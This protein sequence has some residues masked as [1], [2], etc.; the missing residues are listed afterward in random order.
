M[1]A[2]SKKTLLNLAGSAAGLA[3]SFIPG[4]GPVA[5]KILS[6]FLSNAG[7]M[8]ISGE[9]AVKTPEEIRDA[10]NIHGNYKDGGYAP[11]SIKATHGGFLKPLTEDVYIAS[12]RTHAAGGIG[13]DTNADGSPELE[14][15]DNE[16]YFDFDD[17]GGFFVNA[18]TSEKYKNSF[19]NR[20]DRISAETNNVVKKLA[21]AENEK[22]RT[23][24]MAEKLFASKGSVKMEAGGEW[25]PKTEFLAPASTYSFADPYAPNAAVSPTTFTPEFKYMGNASDYSFAK[26]NGTTQTTPT[27]TPTTDEPVYTTTAPGEQPT[28]AK[29]SGEMTSG[30]KAILA[31]QM[32]PVVYNLARG[33]FEKAEE[34]KP[35]YHPYEDTV[36]GLMKDRVYNPQ[37]V[38][39]QI[40]YAVEAGKE[41]ITE[42]TTSASVARSN[43]QKLFN[44]AFTQK[45]Q[46][47]LSGQQMNN[48][49][50]A[51]LANTYDS[52][53]RMRMAAED[54]ADQA[55][56]ANMVAKDNYI[57]TGVSQLGAGLDAYGNT[58][59]Q[60]QLNTVLSNILGQVSPN[61]MI[62]SDGKIT[63]KKS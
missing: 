63:F 28:T 55:T 9:E 14:F 15:E 22:N 5:S 34:V 41:S 40:D 62:G 47:D 27:V 13:G 52:F 56:W 24:K 36:I 12:G 38:Q 18:E 31:G 61:F 32:V 10:T 49:F 19:S 48:Q 3:T 8:L 4:V 39:N 23:A 17:K 59:N 26:T 58:K 53:G 30:D 2:E 35:N 43:M 11:K 1:N 25:K 42:N 45:A 51:D 54:A 21:M 20:K 6:P 44:N 16:L 57:S 50:K 7:N 46:A 29:V 33:L 37:T 60:N